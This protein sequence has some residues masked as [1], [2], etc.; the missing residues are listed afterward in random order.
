M[1]IVVGSPNIVVIDGKVNSEIA[2]VLIDTRAK[3]NPVGLISNHQ[4]PSWFQ[5][6][7][8]GTNSPNR[9]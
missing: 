8:S 5:N 1:L 7:F 6:I 3:G 2:Q 4:E 9:C